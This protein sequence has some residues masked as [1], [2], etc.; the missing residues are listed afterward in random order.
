MT[1]RK[2]G[3]VPPARKLRGGFSLI[4]LLIAIAIVAFVLSAASAFF[5]MSVKQYKLQ[6]KIVETNVEGVIGLELFRRDLENLGFGLPWNDLP[7]SGALYSERTAA[8][9][10][11]LNDFPNAPRAVVSIDCAAF[12]LNQ[13]DY[14][15]IKA[16]SVGL[17]NAAGKWTTLTQT[18]SKRPWTP[19]EE[20]LV[21]GDFVI[22]L[23]LGSNDTNRR[24]LV[25]PGGPYT[26]FNNTAG[27]V[28]VD[29]FS[30]NIIYGINSDG[31]MPVR[32]FN[33]AEYYIAD[34]AST[35]PVTVP[36]RCATNTGVLVKALVAHDAN[37]TTP[38][39]LP[40]LDCVA[41]MQVVFG[42]DTDA[43]G[44]V[45]TWSTDISAGMTAANIRTQLVEVQ[46]YILA[47]EGLRDDT[48]T[49]LTNPILV[50][51]AAVGGGRNFNITGF[52][53]Y[54][55]KLYTIVVKPRN[56]AQ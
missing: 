34:N 37:G 22:V 46:V 25:N 20:N 2:A 13:S 43:D 8:G 18:D 3:P 10:A 6:S 19:A 11:A 5:I 50:G 24:S 15:V 35:P 38:N 12:T 40:L 56:L 28:P 9:L 39:P 48:Y 51:S 33:R 52:Q 30:A 54:R 14:L 31:T 4:E 55:W 41:D 23:N 36:Q 53:N 42:L 16:A 26:L 44:A 47:Q 49:H 45:N 7:T 1:R 21:N 27:F 32:P 17:D 29:P